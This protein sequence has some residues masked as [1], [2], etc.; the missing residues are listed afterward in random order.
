M[1][2]ETIPDALKSNLESLGKEKFIK[3]FYLA[4]GTALA[5]QLGHRISRDLDF[6]TPKTF[7]EK[8]LISILEKLGKLEIDTLEVETILGVLNDT[9]IS[10]FFYRYLLV[11][12]AVSFL[13]VNLADIKEIG[14]MK[15]DAVQSRGKKRDFIDI[16]AILNRGIK[17]EELFYW[18]EKKYAGVKY[19][20]QHILKSLVY[21]ADAENDDMP[22]MLKKISWK[23][24]KI[25]IENEV[26]KFAG[27]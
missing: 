18:F 15:L 23:E 6:F 11:L 13:G 9:R 7:S 4:G 21:F 24:I 27:K 8:K 25:Y 10:F 3:Q 12:P 2:L 20:K 16:W 19:N 26:K 14:A 5:L 17:L 22:Q 1:F